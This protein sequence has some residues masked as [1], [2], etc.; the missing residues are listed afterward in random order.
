MIA[1]SDPM[2]FPVAYDLLKSDWT[3][4]GI[5]TYPRLPLVL[6]SEGMG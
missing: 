4:G 1:R 2:S 5:P 3:R 6:M